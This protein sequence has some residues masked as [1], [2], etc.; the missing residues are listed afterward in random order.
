[1]CEHHHSAWRLWL[2]KRCCAFLILCTATGLSLASPVGQE[3]SP[4]SPAE[5]NQPAVQTAPVIV[6]GHTLFLV[7]G[8][9]AYPAEKRAQ[10]IAN[11]IRAVAADHAYSPQSLRL[12]D[13]PVG[14]RILAGTQLIMTVS[15]SDARMEGVHRQMVAQAYL[16]RIGE[17]IIE[18][19]HDRSPRTLAQ[20]SMF[21]TV[22]TLG[23]L[24]FLWVGQRIF[25]K[26]RSAL[27]K[28]YRERIHGLHIQSFNILRAEHMWRLLTGALS[29]V[30]A[31]IVLI[32]VYAD[33]HYALVLFPWTRGFGNSLF[34]LVVTPVAAMG[35]SLLNA[36]PELIF[37]AILMVFTKYALKLIRLFFIG[38][39]T[40]ALTFSGFD[41]GWAQPTSRLVRVAVVAFALVVAYP[42]IPGSGSQAFKGIT[43]FIGLI[44]SLGSTSF[45][46]NIIS[47][48]SMAYR[49]LF[50]QGDRIKIGDYVGDVEEIK[51]MSTYLRT[52]KNELVAVPNS[53]I[54]NSEVVNYSTLA[55]KEGLVLHTT[56]GIGYETSWR[57]V[58]AMLLQAAARTSG[59][60]REPKPFVLQKALGD[61]AVTYEIN[62]YTCEPRSMYQLYT[63][64]HSNI[65]DVF[66]E[67]GVQIMTPAYEMDPEQVK[68]VPKDR[69]YAEP[70]IRPQSEDAGPPEK[71]AAAS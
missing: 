20:R 17:A 1:M 25:R 61:F 65:L 42:Y 68:I 8:L 43:L 40:G 71:Q 47:G 3:Q 64:L 29:I 56:V 60:L 2:L 44:F 45:I 59:L 70:A 62:A 51:L 58:E 27:E 22:A 24:I 19:R 49:R 55:R 46:G 12:E 23:L 32:T 5:E 4:D 52:P 26:G 69:W 28:R 14:T 18:F 35:A 9:S 34:T 7:R 41:P 66:N 10:D 67:F 53:M 16:S 54:V 50:K 13:A 38:I 39:E 31:V 37:L 15:D 30:W 57:Q 6:D 21:A 36:I 48:Y 11:R 63:A 33:L